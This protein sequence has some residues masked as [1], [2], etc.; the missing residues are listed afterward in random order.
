MTRSVFLLQSDTTAAWYL[1]QYFLKQGDRV[2][3][4]DDFK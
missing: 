2:L 1:E 3:S 4:F